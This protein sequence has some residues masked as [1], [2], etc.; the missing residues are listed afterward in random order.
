MAKTKF[1]NTRTNI[2]CSSGGT[3]RVTIAATVG[4]G[5]SGTSLPCRGCFISLPAA[6]TGPVRLNIATAASA[7]VGVELPEAISPL[8]IS[9]DDVSKLY[10]YSATNGDIID[11]LY[12]LD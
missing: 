12:L 6:N 3:I 4:Q 11:I 1:A 8:F 10:F 2:I 9:I 7:T 5:N